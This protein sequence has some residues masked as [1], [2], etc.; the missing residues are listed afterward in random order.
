MT[1]KFLLSISLLLSFFSTGLNAK[2]SEFNHDP[3]SAV[4]ADKT[5][6]AMGGRE[7]YDK[8]KFISWNFFGKRFHIWDKHT[9][10]IRIEF[11]EQFSDVLIMNV[12]TK[13]GKW[14]QNGKLV[15]DQAAL[16][17]KLEWGYRIWINDSYWVVM[18]FKLHDPGVN[19]TYAREDK[20][21]TGEP[22]DVITMT[23]NDVGV[24]PDNK[25]E[26]FVDK[27]THLIREFAFYKTV[28]TPKPRFRMPWAN[29]QTYNGVL[30]A[31]D[32]G[33]KG[34]APINTYQQLGQ[35]VMT[36]NT[37]AID[38]DGKPIPRMP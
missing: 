35:N 10:D 12:H 29:Y 3:Q 24:T 38:I 32:R 28:D 33:N 23:F 37:P 30:L 7:N 18:P 4:I 19:L 14:W 26:L 1:I 21:L 5:V 8:I 17:K 22:V 25:Y 36:T 2:P 20:S 6:L 9:G 34:M 11:G 31:D 13:V 15:T 27:K 16:D